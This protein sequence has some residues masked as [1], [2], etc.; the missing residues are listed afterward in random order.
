MNLG[1][2]APLW[3]DFRERLRNPLQLR[4]IV[5]LALVLP[6]YFGVY[7][8]FRGGVADADRARAKSEAH[9]ALTNEVEALRAEAA[10]FRPRLPVGTASTPTYGW[11]S[12]SRRR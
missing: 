4:V 10:R 5:G 11:S 1:S 3:N 8:A 6:W 7:P 9:L 12:S 2:L